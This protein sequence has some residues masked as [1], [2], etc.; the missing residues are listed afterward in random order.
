M[1]DVMAHNAKRNLDAL[2]E[3]FNQ[4]VKSQGMWPLQLPDLNPCD[5]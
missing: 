1:Q 4:Q 2:D 3:V 5:P